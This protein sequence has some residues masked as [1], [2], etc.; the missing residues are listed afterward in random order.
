MIIR[1]RPKED[2]DVMWFKLQPWNL[3]ADY[4]SPNEI[5]WNM[6]SRRLAPYS[7][8][9]VG[10]RVTTVGP[11]GPTAGEM[12][13]EVEVTAVARGGYDD[14]DQAWTILRDGL[15]AM[16]VRH[17]GVIKRGFLQNEYTRAAVTTGYLLGFASKQVK[18]LA[19][20]R[21]SGLQMRQH[22]WAWNDTVTVGGPTAPRTGRG[23]VAGLRRARRRTAGAVHRRRAQCVD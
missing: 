17:D 1:D 12:L 2:D 13:W 9:N 19:L 8:L 14:H 3:T 11:G 16:N 18:R 4:C 23:H 15:G 21:P 22:G 6:W 5:E 20:P 7:D 10:D